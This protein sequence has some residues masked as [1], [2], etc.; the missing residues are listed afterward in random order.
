MFT[1]Q[2][3]LIYPPGKSMSFHKKEKEKNESVARP[4][5]PQ[6]LGHHYHRR[7]TSPSG[8]HD[9]GH[10][11]RPE[12]AEKEVDILHFASGLAYNSIFCSLLFVKMVIDF[13]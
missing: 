7:A 2:G 12:S 4:D 8:R 13:L 6:V 3:A 1:D 9:R 11:L 10:L 5:H